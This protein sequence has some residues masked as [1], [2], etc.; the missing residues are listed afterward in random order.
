M[1]ETLEKPLHDIE[2]ERLQNHLAAIDRDPAKLQAFIA[3]LYGGHRDNPQILYAAATHLTAV[4][5]LD[6]D[7]SQEQL[8]VP[9][10]EDATRA[11]LAYTRLMAMATAEKDAPLYANNERVRRRLGGTVE[12]LGFHAALTYATAQGADFV[13][14]PAPAK[15]DFS[16]ADE[17]TDVHIH[18]A[19]PES[20][21]LGVQVGYRPEAK[22]AYHPRIPVLSL[23]TA[24]G[25]TDRAAE[26]RGLLKDIGTRDDEI[27]GDFA[28]PARE[29]DILMTS[30]AAI[31]TAAQS[32]RTAA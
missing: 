27:E 9:S 32:W 19:A 30:S 5:Y 4:T 10:P 13:A 3:E 15:I 20:S 11:F 26:V 21:S 16:G 8:A 12:E 6:I 31:L 22:G 29:H 7:P 14:L 24:L 17:A 2:R 1:T 18:F 23:A 25:G 28:L